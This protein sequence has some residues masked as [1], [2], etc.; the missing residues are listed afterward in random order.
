MAT[1]TGD[2]AH[3]R[4]SIALIVEILATGKRLSNI[5]GDTRVGIAKGL[6]RGI[7]NHAIDLEKKNGIIPSW[8]IPS[9]IM[10]YRMARHMLCDKIRSINIDEQLETK[11][12]D[13]TSWVKMAAM[14]IYELQPNIFTGSL[15]KI[16]SR[17]NVEITV[18]YSKNKCHNCGKYKVR[19]ISQQTRSADESSTPSLQC[20]GCNYVTKLSS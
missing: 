10:T 5:A 6:E 7:Y 13:P 16:A 11:L 19:E 9:F 12:F 3:R 2:V 15:N 4:E 18:V 20:D 14:P 17:K 8:V 1:F